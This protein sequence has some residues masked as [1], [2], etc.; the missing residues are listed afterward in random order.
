[1]PKILA[2]G[3]T[4][5]CDGPSGDHGGQINFSAGSSMLTISGGGAV[6]AGQEVGLTIASCLHQMP[7]PAAPP[8]KVVAPCTVTQGATDGVSRNL[9]VQ[10]QGVLLEGATGPT[11]SIDSAEKPTWKINDAG[12]SLLKVDS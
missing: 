9:T 8:P 11:T 12:Q 1:M 7:N 3:G 10:G 5:L 6:V 4:G 2:V